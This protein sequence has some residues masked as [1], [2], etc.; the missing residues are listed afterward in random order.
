MIMDACMSVC[1]CVHA[2]VRLCVYVSVSIKLKC[3][4]VLATKSKSITEIKLTRLNTTA[5]ITVFRTLAV[6][7][8]RLRI[9]QTLPCILP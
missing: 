2:C 9:M 8:R 3:K 7:A 1:V 4:P 5:N 6:A